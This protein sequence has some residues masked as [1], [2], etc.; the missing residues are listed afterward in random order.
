MNEDYKYKT[1]IPL[2]RGDVPQGNPQEE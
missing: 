2:L 1:P